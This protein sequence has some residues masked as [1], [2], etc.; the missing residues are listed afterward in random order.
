MSAAARTRSLRACWRDWCTLE[1]LFV[2]F[3]EGAVSA[4]ENKALIRRLYDEGFTQWN[5]AVIDEW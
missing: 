4:E 3:D 5:L 1:A 2:L